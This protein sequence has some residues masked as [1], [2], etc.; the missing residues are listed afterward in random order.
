MLGDAIASKKTLLTKLIVNLIL[1]P[2]IASILHVTESL[3]CMQPK[4]C[5]SHFEDLKI[6]AVA[7]L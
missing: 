1:K 2:L 7:K 4:S 5:A 3:D 6:R